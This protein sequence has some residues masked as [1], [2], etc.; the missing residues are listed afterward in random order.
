LKPLPAFEREN[1]VAIGAFAAILGG[2][3]PAR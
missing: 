2:R 3:L 1:D